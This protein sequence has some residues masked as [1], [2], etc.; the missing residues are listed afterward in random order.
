M[1][2]PRKNYKQE[3]IQLYL[4]YFLVQVNLA[5]QTKER[6]QMEKKSK[7]WKKTRKTMKQIVPRVKFS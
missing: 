4:L 1:Q 7:Q 5:P 2:Q 3:V 6:K